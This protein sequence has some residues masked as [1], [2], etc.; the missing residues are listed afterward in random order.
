MTEDYAAPP[1]PSRSCHALRAHCGPVA[2]K[3]RSAQQPG[4]PVAVARAACGISQAE[5]AIRTS[6]HESAISRIERGVQVPSGARRVSVAA[7]LKRPVLELFPND[8]VTRDDV[9]EYLGI[10]VEELQARRRCL[11]QKRPLQEARNA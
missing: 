2:R 9:A 5:L 11:A 10:S 3:P 4:H 1:D 8:P 7:A 6:L